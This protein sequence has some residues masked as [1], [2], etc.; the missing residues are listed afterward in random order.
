MKSLD[1]KCS[2][3]ILDNEQA[4]WSSPLWAQG[5]K[6]SSEALIHAKSLMVSVSNDKGDYKVIRQRKQI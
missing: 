2:H 6:G 4:G 1:L 3:L 5:R